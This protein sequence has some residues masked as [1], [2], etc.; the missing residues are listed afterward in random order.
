ML[1]TL[2][3]DTKFDHKSVCKTINKSRTI[4]TQWGAIRDT[5]R[6]LEAKGFNTKIE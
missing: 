4:S 2:A 1:Q 6:L 5:I 3:D